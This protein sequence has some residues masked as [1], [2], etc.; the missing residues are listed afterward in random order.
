MGVMLGSQRSTTGVWHPAV[1][2]L[3][4][5]LGLFQGWELVLAL[6]DSMRA[7]QLHLS[8]ASVS[9]LLLY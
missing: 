9:V 8:S 5:S 7:S 6:R 2:S 4:T 1:P 3:T